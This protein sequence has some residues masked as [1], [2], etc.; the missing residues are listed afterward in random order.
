MCKNSPY[1]FKTMELCERWKKLPEAVGWKFI[2]PY[3]LSLPEEV[4]DAISDE[5]AKNDSI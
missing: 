3:R 1:T 4:L 5:Q 2:G